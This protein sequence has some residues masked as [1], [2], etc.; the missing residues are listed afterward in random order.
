MRR[1][2]LCHSLNKDKIITVTDGMS[3]LYKNI[4]SHG[5]SRKIS[6]TAE[7]DLNIPTI[8]TSNIIIPRTN[9]NA[10]NML[11]KTENTAFFTQFQYF[12]FRFFAY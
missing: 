2:V 11:M 6:G 5:V 8:K 10:I 1:F 9:I 4:L 3:Q 7:K 12:Q